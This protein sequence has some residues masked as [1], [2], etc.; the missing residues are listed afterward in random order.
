MSDSCLTC[1]GLI[2][3]PGIAYGYAGKFCQCVK[4]PQ[5]CRPASQELKTQNFGSRIISNEEYELRGEILTLKSELSAKDLRIK[6]LEEK[7]TALSVA[8]SSVNADLHRDFQRERSRAETF[9]RQIMDSNTELESLKAKLER[10]TNQSGIL[11]SKYARTTDKNLFEIMQ[12]VDNE[13]QSGGK[14]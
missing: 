9:K 8:P 12:E 14:G 4:P 1:G 3:E 7:L 6:R 11:L 2:P 10:V 13:L 5:I